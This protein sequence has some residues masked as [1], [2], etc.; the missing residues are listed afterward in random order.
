M[1]K[2]STLS[3]TG[4]TIENDVEKLELEQERLN[5]SGKE[6]A[7]LRFPLFGVP[8]PVVKKLI[9]KLHQLRLQQLN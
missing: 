7:F 6:K 4:I 1:Q 2:S 3:S 5:H 8:D 9:E